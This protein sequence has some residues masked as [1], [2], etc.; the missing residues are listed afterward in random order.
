MRIFL[1]ILAILVLMVTVLAAGTVLYALETRVP[2]ITIIQS[3][4]I[5]AAEARDSF[6]SLQGQ[7]EAGTCTGHVFREESPVLEN[8]T[9]LNLTLRLH[10]RC[11]LPMEWIE[12][13][14]VPEEGDILEE[15]DERPKVLAAFAEGDLPLR[16]LTENE[17]MSRRIR[18]RYYL[19]GKAFDTEI[20]VNFNPELAEDEQP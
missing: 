3:R 19:L 16:I 12:T 1:K 5:P 13:A 14:V 20:Q 15:R 2:E 4:A 7:L 8:S 6:E 18:I 10:N 11:L 17:N 9:F